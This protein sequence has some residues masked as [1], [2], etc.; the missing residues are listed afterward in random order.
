MKDQS[1]S[2]KALVLALVLCLLA[3]VAAV[4]EGVPEPFGFTAA[5]GDPVAAAGDE[6]VADAESEWEQSYI[7]VSREG[8]VE[9]IPV[10]TVRVI[11][12]DTTIAM[13]PE[14]FTHNVCEGVDTFTYD[15]WLGEREVYYSVYPVES[16]TP[17]QL[18]AELL[19][20]H[21]NSY[22]A[23]N[24]SAVKVGSY[25][26][27]AVWFDGEKASPSYQ[28]H[29][30]LIPA[31]DGCIVLETQFD[32]EMYEGLYRIMLSLFDTLKIG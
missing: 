14:Y 28:R 27:T 16:T 21:G 23:G 3:A 11:N 7:Q 18:C 10:E 24:V 12:F 17:E 4:A 1:K 15:A 19:A 30:F 26:A 32:F 29:F 22:A 5:N 8:V 31:W 9:Q 20:R 6:A 13:D 25:D 2:V